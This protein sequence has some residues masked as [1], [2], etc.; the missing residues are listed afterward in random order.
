M[1]EAYAFSK[2]PWK[3]IGFGVLAIAAALT[4]FL[5]Q[6]RYDRLQVK[7]DHLV[8]WGGQVVLAIQTVSDNPKMKSTDAAAQVYAVGRELDDSAEQLATQTTSI[9][10]L[11][12]EA[13]EAKDKATALQKSLATAQR[14]RDQVIARLDAEA[15]DPGEREDLVVMRDELSR[16]LNTLYEA[17]L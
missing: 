14:Q 2:L 15:L 1:F 9:E 17:G 10:R 16:I 4:I 8:E 7:Y 13:N 5:M 12:R 6:A 11:G 3:W